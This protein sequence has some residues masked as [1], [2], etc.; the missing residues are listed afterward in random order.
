MIVMVILGNKRRRR[1]PRSLEKKEYC[2]PSMRIGRRV[3]S[4]MSA[5]APGPS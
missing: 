4:A 3:A 2:A 1:T 5:I